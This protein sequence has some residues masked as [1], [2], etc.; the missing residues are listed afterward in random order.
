[1]LRLGVE[2]ILG[3]GQCVPGPG[4]G[5]VV[6]CTAGRPELAQENRIAKGPGS[7]RALD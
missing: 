3:N 6:E 1:L 2:R 4:F 5:I 7:R